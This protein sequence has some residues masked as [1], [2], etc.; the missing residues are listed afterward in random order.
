MKRI[1][2]IVVIVVI[3]LV[4]SLGACVKQIEAA[5]IYDILRETLANSMSSQEYFVK[6]KTIISSNNGVER[7]LNIK[8]DLDS[9]EYDDRQIVYSTTTTTLASAKTSELMF[10][11]S[12]PSSIKSKKAQLSDYKYYQFTRSEDDAKAKI[13]TTYDEAI[14]NEQFQDLIITNVFASIDELSKEDISFECTNGGAWKEGKITF[15]RFKVLK[16][17]NMY[18]RYES[19]ELHIFN[20]KI[21]KIGTYLHTNEAT[22]ETEASGGLK[23]DNYKVDINYTGPIIR[24]YNYDKF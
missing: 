20:N 21:V 15:I 22:E 9:T 4:M 19:I 17:D 3:S 14:N 11:Y 7:S 10:S 5:D 24:P 12:L 18:N 2:V 1:K 6:E 23:A 16:A 13:E 8:V